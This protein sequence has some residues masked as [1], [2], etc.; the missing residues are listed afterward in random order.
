MKQVFLVDDEYFAVEGLKKFVNWE[1]YDLTVCG[2]AYDGKTALQNIESLQPDIV[3][4]DVR[5]PG[6]NG[7]ELIARAKTLVPQCLFVIISGYNEFDYAR[8]ALRLGVL[9]YIDKPVNLE[10]LDAVLKRI[11]DVFRNRNR[12]L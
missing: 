2:E 10:K 6:L 11:D 7:L 1:K 3:F 8:K 9:D 5:M 12:K 4:T